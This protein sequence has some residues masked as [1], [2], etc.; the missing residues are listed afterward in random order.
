MA[1]VFVGF[2][3]GRLTNRRPSHSHRNGI[4]CCA[5]LAHE[6]EKK[7][8]TRTLPLA[9][10]ARGE[11]GVPAGAHTLCGIR[12]ARRAE[13]GA[14]FRGGAGRDHHQRQGLCPVRRGP[15][16][17]PNTYTHKKTLGNGEVGSGDA[18]PCDGVQMEG[19]WVPWPRVLLAHLLLF[20]HTSFVP[21]RSVFVFRTWVCWLRRSR[22]ASWPWMPRCGKPST[23]PRSA[24][25]SLGVF[26]SHLLQ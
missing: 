15:S 8:H 6:K 5:I 21:S 12:R 4:V 7:T 24:F 9:G 25:V 14:L 18:L 1:R 16:G 22:K 2:A 17:E 10:P 20:P 3:L 11:R 19:H 26:A 13:R 23:T